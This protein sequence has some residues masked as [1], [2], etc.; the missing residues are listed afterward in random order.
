M[1]LVQ[2]FAFEPLGFK[3]SDRK[4]EAASDQ[5]AKHSAAAQP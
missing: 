3:R 1:P 5:I 2:G 4:R